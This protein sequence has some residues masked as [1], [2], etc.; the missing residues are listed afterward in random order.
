MAARIQQRWRFRAPAWAPAWAP[1]V[2]ELR[3]GVRG[4]THTRFPI[5]F[6]PYLGSD[7]LPM[8][9]FFTWP[10]GGVVYAFEGTSEVIMI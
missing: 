3:V 9:G 5:H 10:G 7:G 8:Y 2:L 6:E 1:S 4:W